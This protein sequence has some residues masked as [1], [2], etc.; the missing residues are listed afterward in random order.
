MKTTTRYH[1]GID[2]HKRFSQVHVLR[3][4]GET[5]WKGRIDDNDPALFA[6]L[7][8]QLGG[9]CRAVFEA[10]MNDHERSW[11]SVPN[12]EH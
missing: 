2:A 12:F 8:R 6:G 3:D 9:P 4:D 7:V 10:S 11:G 1:I 5:V